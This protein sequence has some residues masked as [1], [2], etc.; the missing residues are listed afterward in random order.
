MGIPVIDALIADHF[1]IHELTAHLPCQD[2][3]SH[4]RD[5]SHRRKKYRDIK[6]QLANL[7]QEFL[8]YSTRNPVSVRKWSILS[9]VFDSREIMRA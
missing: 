3:V 8:S 1:R 5:A 4:I 2:A 9:I 6:I 7:H